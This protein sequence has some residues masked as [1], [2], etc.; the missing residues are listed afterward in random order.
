MLALLEKPYCYS[1]SR[2]YWDFDAN[3]WKFFQDYIEKNFYS[4]MKMH[5]FSRLDDII[6]ECDTDEIQYFKSMIDR[7][8]QE[9]EHR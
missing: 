5:V 6:A 8:V 4:N 3:Q 1:F 2:I 9:A 7:A